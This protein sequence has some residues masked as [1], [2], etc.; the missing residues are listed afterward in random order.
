MRRQVKLPGSFYSWFLLPA[1]LFSTLAGGGAETEFTPRPLTGQTFIHDPSTIVKAGGRY[2]VFGTGPG[3][4]T[5]SSS[6]M[7]HW[8]NGDSIF[9]RPPAWTKRLVPAFA[10]FGWAPDVICVRGRYLLYY[11][12]STWGK[13]VSAIGLATNATQNPAA[14]NF[15]WHDGG[16]VIHSTNG[17][18]FNAIDPSVVLAADGRLW[19]AFGSFFQG[20]FLTELDSQTGLRPGPDSPLYHLAWNDSIE[21]AC[22]TRH[23]S[24]YYLF[25]NWGKCCKGTNSTYEVR[26]G[27]AEKITG[28]YCDRSGQDLVAGGGSQFLQS[29][30][31]FIGPGHIGIMADGATNG[32]TWFSY[33]F[34]DADTEGHSRLA[35]GRIDWSDGW[36]QPAN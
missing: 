22:L 15:Q 21:A 31:R 35:I 6:D 11:A 13:P 19:L 26:M 29:R 8:Q 2:Y 16:E 25:V 5:K 7:I 4:R 17:T 33:H 9:M 3:I 14:S 20:I 10:G 12:V 34:Y 24:F 18:A 1:I 28:P 27:R 23:G 32:P 30:G 36:P